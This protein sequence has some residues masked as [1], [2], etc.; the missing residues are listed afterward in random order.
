MK[1]ASP[2]TL[3]V[4]PCIKQIRQRKKAGYR[5]GNGRLNGLP[6]G[7]F[8][9]KNRNN[10]PLILLMHKLYLEPKRTFEEIVML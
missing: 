7:R 9:A 2:K 1:E 8:G 10:R 6:T 4:K 3:S 5:K